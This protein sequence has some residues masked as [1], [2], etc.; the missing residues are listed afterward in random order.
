MRL[1]LLILAGMCGTGAAHA[2]AIVV[3]ATPAANAIVDGARVPIDL[4][5]N[6]RVDAS[7]SRLSVIDGA[8][9]TRALV[10]EADAPPNRIR[11]VATDLAPGEQLL[12]W[13]VLSA[14]GHITRGRLKFRVQAKP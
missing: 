5:F 12:E 6:S 4:A 7:R 10:I 2:H 9:R 8:Q 11:S 13:Y 1:L 14:D 3:T